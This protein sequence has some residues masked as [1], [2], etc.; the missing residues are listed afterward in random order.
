[1]TARGAAGPVPDLGR[2]V[3]AGLAVAVRPRLWPSLARLAPSGWWRR[4]PPSPFPPA[5]YVRF[6]TQTMYGDTGHLDRRDL[7]AY[8][9][10]CRRM[11][12]RAR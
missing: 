4:W 9:E 5:E 7:I 11:G 3:A 10:W 6:R 2:A 8:L 1:V 12:S